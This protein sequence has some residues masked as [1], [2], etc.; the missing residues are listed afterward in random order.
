MNQE[1]NQQ[2]EGNWGLPRGLYTQVKYYGVPIMKA[3]IIVGSFVFRYN[4]GIY[5]P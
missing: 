2:Q 3:F 1:E 4:S 5:F